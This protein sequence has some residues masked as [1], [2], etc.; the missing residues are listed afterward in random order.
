VI[1]DGATDSRRFYGE[2]NVVQ[3]TSFDGGRRGTKGNCRRG[4]SSASIARS[5]VSTKRGAAYLGASFAKRRK[6]WFSPNAHI[7][8][9]VSGGRHGDSRCSKSDPSIAAV[10][11]MI[12]DVPQPAPARVRADFT[13]PE[14]LTAEWLPRRPRIRPSRG[15]ILP[16]WLQLSPSGRQCSGRLVGF[17]GG[18][19]L[20]SGGVDNERNCLGLGLLRVHI[21]E[22][23][24]PPRCDVIPPVSQSAIRTR[25]AGT[26]GSTTQTPEGW[27]SFIP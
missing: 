16:H 23:K 6:S 19:A 12:S 21:V 24:R 13:G 11:R 3:I 14:G 18:N 9:P 20:F 10:S 8:C 1:D 15:P 2:A 5:E 25:F 4:P 17:D 7:K 27:H 22:S 26:T